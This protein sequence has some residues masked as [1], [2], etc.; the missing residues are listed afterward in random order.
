M[1]G[2]GLWAPGFRDAGAWLRGE[3]DP[4]VA[5]APAE[6]LPAALRR[7]ASALS[8]M[9]AE[10]ASAAA[11]GSGADLGRVSIVLGSAFGELGAAVEMI[12]SFRDGEGMPSPTRF[13][14][15]VHNT[16]VAYASMAAG[17]HG[18]AT[19]VAAGD[20]TAGAA[21]LEALGVLEERGGE[22]LLALADE[23]VPPPLAPLRPFAPGAVALVLSAAPGPSARARL[24][25]LRR[26]TAPAVRMPEGFAAHPCAGGF[27]L[28]AAAS[29]RRA[30]PVPLG[31][32]GEGW[33]VDLEP[34][35]AA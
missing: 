21:L 12:R 5:S 2:E 32:A 35:S 29:A 27:A 10:V 18:L 15:S 25:G 9:V 7:R 20:D 33:I 26:G 17:N 28:V 1:I 22:V 24:S 16:A 31:A 13:H 8:R 30:G 34:V 3:P 4:A 19:A 11:A 23:A 6:L 14:N